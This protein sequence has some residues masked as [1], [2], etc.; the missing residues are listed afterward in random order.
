MEIIDTDTGFK[1]FRNILSEDEVGFGRSAF[2]KGNEMDYAKMTVFVGNCLKKI[3]P[4]FS[5]TKY[6]ASN[7]TNSSDAGLLHRDVMNYGGPVPVFTLLSYLDTATMRLI[8]GSYKKPRMS[9]VESFEY[10]GKLKHVVVNPG[11]LLMFHSST[12]HSGLFNVP[13]NKNRRLVQMF[14]VYPTREMLEFYNNKQALHIQ[15]DGQKC[16]NS[17][18]GNLANSVSKI[19]GLKFINDMLY[20]NAA[21]GYGH[22][23]VSKDGYTLVSSEAN[24]Q[25]VVP[26][27]PVVQKDNLYYMFIKTNNVENDAQWDHVR[28]EVFLRNYLIILVSFLVMMWLLVFNCRK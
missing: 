8:P 19:G 13:K 22:N 20:F 26:N 6:R 18:I 27:G 17:K 12:I 24:A 5:C 7:N 10:R 9:L 25:R 4:G 23:P 2:L 28:A 21:W 11:D 1:V 3:D 15:C 16:T 14:E